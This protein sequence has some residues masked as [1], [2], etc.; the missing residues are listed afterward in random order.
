MC[1]MLEDSR[2]L[3]NQNV[4]GTM[5]QNWEPS[6]PQGWEPRTV[7]SMGARM[8][9]EKCQGLQGQSTCGA[10]LNTRWPGNH[11]LGDCQ[12]RSLPAAKPGHS[13]SSTPRTLGRQGQPSL[14]HLRPHFLPAVLYPQ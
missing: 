5:D 6:Q 11:L 1:I 3:S 12:K 10:R 4:E 7:L 9:T 2:F 8:S 14:H 13:P